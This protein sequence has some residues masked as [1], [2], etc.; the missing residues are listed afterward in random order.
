MDADEAEVHRGSDRATGQAI[1]LRVDIDGRA[2]ANVDA[3]DLSTGA[4]LD[5]VADFGVCKSA[6]IHADERGADGY[7]A[8]RRTDGLARE[9]L[10][11][12][13]QHAERTGPVDVCEVADP[14]LVGAG[15]VEDHHGSTEAYEATA[16][17]ERQQVDVL[18][19]V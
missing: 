12:R 17:S 16:S 1:G 4:D 3:A 14:G 6:D 5:V 19:E 11:R 7:R 13:G 2:G 9:I 10:R 15:V 18:V 8:G